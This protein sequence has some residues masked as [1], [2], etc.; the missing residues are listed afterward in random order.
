MTSKPYLAK[1]AA[2]YPLWAL[3]LWSAESSTC[4]HWSET[5]RPQGGP[6]TPPTSNGLPQFPLDPGIQGRGEGSPTILTSTRS[7]R[8]RSLSAGHWRHG[9]WTDFGGE[10]TTALGCTGPLCPGQ[11][12]TASATAPHQ[13]RPIGGLTTHLSGAGTQTDPTGPD[14]GRMHRGTGG[15][16]TVATPLPCLL[17][18]VPGALR[19]MSR[20]GTPRAGEPTATTAHTP[21]TGLRRSHPATAHWM[22]CQARMAGKKGVWRGAR[23]AWGILL[24]V[25]HGQSRAWPQ[26]TQATPPAP[27]EGTGTSSL[28]LPCRRGETSCPS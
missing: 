25:G 27:D 13:G 20:R 18:S 11:T 22:L 4:P 7:F 14:P 15:A 5:C 21:L 16:D 9:S 6:A 2:C 1:P 17:A 26:L 23:W 10:D 12:G 28:S 8:T 3:R 19:R 24:R